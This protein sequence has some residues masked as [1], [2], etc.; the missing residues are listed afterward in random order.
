MYTWESN[1][2]FHMQSEI[3]KT[4]LAKLYVLMQPTR[5]R[6]IQLLRK[7]PTNPMY[8]RE[9]AEKI[10]ESERNTSFHLST[11]AEHGF[12]TGEYREISEPTHHSS[13]TGRA[14]KFYSITP[15]VDEIIKK[16]AKEI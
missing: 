6:I 7:N 15:K 4:D 8:I 3:D 2:R 11:L 13:V 14:A 9:I 10:V 1:G 5:Q 16:I 12:V